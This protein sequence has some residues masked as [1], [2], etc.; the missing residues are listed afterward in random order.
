MTVEAHALLVQCTT[1]G[2]LMSYCA[3][4]HYFVTFRKLVF[5]QLIKVVM[6]CT[7]IILLGLFNIAY[8]RV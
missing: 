3:T 8:K 6:P 4:S 7:L 2:N 1:G 5:V